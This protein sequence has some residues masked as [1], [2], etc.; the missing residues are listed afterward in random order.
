MAIPVESTLSTTASDAVAAAEM[1]RSVRRGGSIAMVSGIL[2]VVIAISIPLLFKN[3][4]E[5]GAP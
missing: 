5:Y 4:V 3:F 1:P 2:F